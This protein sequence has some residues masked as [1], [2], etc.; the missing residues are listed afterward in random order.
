M[1]IDIHLANDGQEGYDKALVLL[2]DLILMDLHM[3]VMDG[4]EAVKLIREN[5]ILEKTPVVALS[6]DA[7][8][9]QQRG[10]LE[11][12]FDDYITKPVDL[13]RDIPVFAKYLKPK[14][15]E[16]ELVT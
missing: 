13:D 14:Q 2:P 15:Q 3:P 11:A 12:G 4:F 16:E 8:L 5:P 7:F 10:A 1:N 9:E 6:A